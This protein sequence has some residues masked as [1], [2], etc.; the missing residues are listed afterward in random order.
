MLPDALKNLPL[1]DAAKLALRQGNK[2]EA[3]KLVREA[4]G[5]GLKEAKDVVE[6]HVA[7]DP[8]LRAQL[9]SAVQR[10]RPG[11]WLWVVVLLIVGGL[12][13]F[14]LLR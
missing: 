10:S 5:L 9:E 3:I 11:P 13:G 1:P 6:A 12:I 4:H 8:M 7:G 2:I 14:W